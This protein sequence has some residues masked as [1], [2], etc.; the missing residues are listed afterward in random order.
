M[1]GSVVRFTLTGGAA[2]LVHLAIAMLLIRLGT[3]PLIS[4]AAA[5]TIAFLVSFWGH[6]R[7]T[8]AGHGTGTWRSLRRFVIVAGAGFIINELAFVLLLIFSAVSAEK[9]LFI[10]TLTAAM[11]TFLLSRYWAFNL[12]R[13]EF[14]LPLQFRDSNH[15]K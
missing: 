4:N 12:S 8:F 10:S 6:H 2:T 3:A 14:E 1:I 11:C 5:F 7:F 9:S 15:S 13:T